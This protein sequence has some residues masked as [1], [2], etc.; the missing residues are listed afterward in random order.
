M[1]VEREKNLNFHH[2][3]S[4]IASVWKGHYLTKETKTRSLTSEGKKTGVV[5]IPSWQERD[6]ALSHQTRLG[7]H[8]NL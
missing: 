1:Q 8:G 3:V 4:N 5:T 6:G 2:A 7:P